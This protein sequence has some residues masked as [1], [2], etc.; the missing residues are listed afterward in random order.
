MNRFAIGFTALWFALGA[1]QVLA[2]TT[3]IRYATIKGTASA[4]SNG[5]CTEPGYANQCPSGSCSCVQVPSAT[6]GKV[7]GQPLIDGT[8]TANVF[9]T[10]DNGATTSGSTGDCTPF[11][12]VAEFATTRAGKASSETLNL[13]GVSCSSLTAGANSPILGGFGIA[14]SPKPVN[15]GKGFGKV[16]GFLDTTGSVSLTLHGP[17]TE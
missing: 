6:V 5:Q 10:L 2:V 13:N 16:S 4:P 8:G 12:G 11:F 3:A 9:L 1:T 17:I 14:T 15:G 7:P